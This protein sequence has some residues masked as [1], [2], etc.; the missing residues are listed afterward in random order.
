M[1]FCSTWRFAVKSFC[2]YVHSIADVMLLCFNGIV[3]AAVLSETLQTFING[4]YNLFAGLW[5]LLSFAVAPIAS[6]VFM[7]LSPIAA[8]V[9][10][11]T[12]LISSILRAVRYSINFC[13]TGDDLG[14]HF[15]LVQLLIDC[16]AQGH[17][18]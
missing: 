5:H 9:A 18:L 4:L 17:V 3:I 7:A 12:K 1:D 16:A 2:K 15:K 14:F 6:A 11:V 8:L 13:L 10:P